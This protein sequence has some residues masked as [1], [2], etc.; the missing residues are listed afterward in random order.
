[1]SSIRKV[2]GPMPWSQ[3]LLG[4][5]FAVPQFRRGPVAETVEALNNRS[6]GDFC[7]EVFCRH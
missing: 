2:R 1:M 5:W 6:A 3:P 7:I 4:D